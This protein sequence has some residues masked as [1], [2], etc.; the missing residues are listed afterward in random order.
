[1]TRDLTGS[2]MC[3]A[4][5]RRTWLIAANVSRVARFTA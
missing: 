5:N 4:A 2:S 1:M 3:S